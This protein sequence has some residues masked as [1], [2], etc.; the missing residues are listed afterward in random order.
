MF[1]KT[2]ATCAFAASGVALAGVNFHNGG[3]E[4]NGATPSYIA[5]PSGSTAIDG[6]TTTDSGA[7]WFDAATVGGESPDGGFVV[8]IANYTY[9][10]GGIQQTLSL[11]VGQSYTIGFYLGTSSASGRT[12]TAEVIVEAAGSSGS[13][14]SSISIEGLGTATTWTYHE[15]EFI[16]ADSETTVSF[17]NF[18]NA[19]RHFAMIDGVRVVPA[20]SVVAAGFIGLAIAGTKRRR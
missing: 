16:A 15:F 13:E 9:S 3:F 4:P 20:P 19:N 10:A 8:D 14:M 2:V 7:E 5:L 17:R 11:T 1:M 6:W 18:Q 12:G